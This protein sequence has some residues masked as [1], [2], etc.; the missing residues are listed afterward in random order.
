VIG[1]FHNQ[2]ES[3]QLLVENMSELK[4]QGVQTLYLEGLVADLHDADVAAYFASPTAPMPTSL[5]TWSDGIA[6]GN[7]IDP[8]GRGTYRALLEAARAN[9]IQ[10]K[11]LDCT[12][13]VIEEELT[14]SIDSLTA[15]DING[16]RRL[17]KMNF[18]AS[19]MIRQH[20]SATGNEKWVAL[21]GAGHINT[22]QGVPTVSD[23]TDAVGVWI[24]VKRRYRHADIQ[25]GHTLRRKNRGFDYVW[26]RPPT[27]SRRRR[28]EAGHER[29]QRRL[30]NAPAYSFHRR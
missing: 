30:F 21:V 11:P 9:E 29:S 13:T 6:R 26:K 24:K 1:E 4:R 28:H 27:G 23:L 14:R 19:A 25:P 2:P 5:Q 7:G 10:V 3:K 22:L 12:A 17:R 8:A 18:F 16:T 15:D 20:Q